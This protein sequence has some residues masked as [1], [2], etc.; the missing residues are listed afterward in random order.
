MSYLLHWIHRI[1]IFL[2]NGLGLP[3]SSIWY[4]ISLQMFLFYHVTVKGFYLKFN[5]PY[6]KR[7][8]KHSRESAK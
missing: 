5:I 7:A 2:I 3:N 6:L 1:H 4:N 8:I